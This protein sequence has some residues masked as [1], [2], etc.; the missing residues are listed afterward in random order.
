MMHTRS[1]MSLTI[2]LLL[3]VMAFLPACATWPAMAHEAAKVA[4]GKVEPHYRAK[5]IAVAKV[6]A[7][8]PA[9]CPSLEAC[10]M[11]RRKID[12]AIKL[13]HAAAKTW[14]EVAPL[15]EVIK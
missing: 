10:L 12:A 13:V 2:V 9:E 15:V 1:E 14:V 8:R 4:S 5:C 11:E 7:P 3:V 6:C